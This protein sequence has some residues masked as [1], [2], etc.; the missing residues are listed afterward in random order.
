MNKQE[1]RITISRY[2]VTVEHRWYLWITRLYSC[3]DYHE[4]KIEKNGSEEKFI[5][6]S[7][8]AVHPMHMSGFTKKA[9]V[10]QHYFSNMKFYVAVKELIIEWEDY[11]AEVAGYIHCEA[12]DDLIDKSKWFNH[13]NKKPDGNKCENSTDSKQL[14]LFVKS[15]GLRTT[16]IKIGNE[17]L[18]FYPIEL[19]KCEVKSRFQEE[20]KGYG[21]DYLQVRREHQL[22]CEIRPLFDATQRLPIKYAH[23]TV[24]IYMQ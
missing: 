1:G 15:P 2:A 14:L 6:D 19:T 24:E 3:A 11:Q 20:M 9:F 10:H 4:Y 8:Q 21:R 18:V 17:D 5:Y 16:N 7:Q 22:N 23:V 12:C 13:T